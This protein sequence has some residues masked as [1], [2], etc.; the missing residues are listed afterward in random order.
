MFIRIKILD[1]LRGVAALI[2]LFHHLFKLNEFYFEK[3][4][5]TSFFKI[6]NLISGLN[7][8][9]V[10]FFFILS[11][12]SIGLSLQ[13]RILNTKAS[14]N[15]YL[16][17]R[18]KRILPIYWLA[19]I[20]TLF[21]GYVAR[22]TYNQDF[23]WNN[24]VGNIL[25]LQS[26]ASATDAWFNPYG[27]NGPLWSLSFEMFF[28]LFF[29]IVYY[30]NY[31]YFKS[32]SIFLK[33]S[34]LFAFSL[35]AIIFNKKVLFIP[36]LLFFTNFGTWILGYLSSQYFLYKKKYNLFFIT[37]FLLGIIMMLLKDKIPSDT[38]HVMA[39]GLLMNGI[40][41]FAIH[42]FQK[43]DWSKLE[44]IINFLFFKIGEGSYAIYA[45]HYPLLILLEKQKITIINQALIIIIFIIIS[46]Y[47]ERI[48]VRFKWKFLEINYL[49]VR[50]K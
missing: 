8:E 11:G 32:W 14:L 36:Y 47:I 10:M 20:F 9:A 43:Y 40:F 48:T 46:I 22:I 7:H 37:S 27:L 45:L 4:T 33:F 3:V 34:L 6:L 44:K 1:S 17:R 2:V 39:K 18:F 28:Y 29:P 16:Y 24:L 49:K 12:F 23:S 42:F 26:S 21:I 25:F 38:I 5:T 19:L 31:R 41:Y 13:N 50:A 15:Y 30:L 35:L